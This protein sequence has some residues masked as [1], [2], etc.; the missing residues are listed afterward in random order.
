MKVKPVHVS[1]RHYNMLSKITSNIKNKTG[2]PKTYRWVMQE[3]IDQAEGKGTDDL[4][5]QIN[6]Y[7]D[8]KEQEDEKGWPISISEL[9]HN[10]ITQMRNAIREKLKE[11][12][13][14]TKEVVYYY[15]LAHHWIEGLY[16]NM[17]PEKK[18]KV[19]EPVVEVC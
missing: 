14:D 12:R 8:R 19:E 16:Y 1:P 5:V 2:Y 6:E 10:K 3:L 17:F 9:H 18:K 7:I 11:E 15:H 13:G 4:S